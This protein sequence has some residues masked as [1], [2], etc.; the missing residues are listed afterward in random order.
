LSLSRQAQDQHLPFHQRTLC[1]PVGH[2]PMLGGGLFF[3]VPTIA[4]KAFLLV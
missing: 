3:I 1:S 2:H 4:I